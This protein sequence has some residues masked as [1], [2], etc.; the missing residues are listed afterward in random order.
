MKGLP[1][2]QLYDLESDI[3]E[4]HNVFDAHPDVVKR[5]TALLRKYADEGRSTPGAPQKNDTPVDIWYP[6][7]RAK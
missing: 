3:A 6:K 7:K 2:I 1:E 4:E 5:L